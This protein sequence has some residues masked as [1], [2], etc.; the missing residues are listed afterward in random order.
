[1]SFFFFLLFCNFVVTH[2]FFFVFVWKSKGYHYPFWASF[3]TESEQTRYQELG[4]AQLGGDW[5]LTDHHGNRR[6]ASEFL[7]QWILLYFGF[8]HCPDICP[9]ELEKLIEIVNMFGEFDEVVQL[10]SIV[11]IWMCPFQANIF[12]IWVGNL[13]LICLNCQ[14]HIVC[15][16]CLPVISVKYSLYEEAMGFWDSLRHWFS[17]L[18]RNVEDAYLFREGEKISIFQIMTI[19]NRGIW[20]VKTWCA[21]LLW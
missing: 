5:T 10:W 2:L 4:K 18:N 3:F 15:T 11:W 20:L 8:T 13:G 12:R 7:G 17:L 16:V 14:C 21:G 1:M 6:S 19:S 9:E